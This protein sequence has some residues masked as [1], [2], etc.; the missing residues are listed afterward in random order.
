MKAAELLTELRDAGVI[1]TAAV[2]LDRPAEVLTDERVEAARLVKP[3]LL[4]LLVH[5]A[6]RANC[7]RDA[8]I[9]AGQAEYSE[10][11]DRLLADASPALRAMIDDIKNTFVE[12]G[13]ATVIEVSRATG[14]RPAGRYVAKNPRRQPVI[15]IIRQIVR[16]DPAR[17]KTLTAQWMERIA[18][19]EDSG[20]SAEAVERVALDEL[21]AAA[22]VPAKRRVS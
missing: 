10:S 16:T 19:S 11:E 15:D 17:A 9:V 5:E 6:D 14:P 22:F 3:E 8:M 2:D 21:T 20:L 4:R 13:G 7:I 12:T 18:L 1:V